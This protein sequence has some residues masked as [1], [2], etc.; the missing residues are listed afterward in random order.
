T[1]HL[2]RY[3]PSSSSSSPHSF[4]PL[5]AAPHTNTSRQYY[6][7][8]PQVTNN[9]TVLYRRGQFQ[10]DMGNNTGAIAIYKKALT[11]NPRDV[12]VLA[13]FGR[14]LYNLKNYTGALRSEDR[15]LSI[16]PTSI[17]ALEWKGF[18]LYHLGDYKQALAT[19][20]RALELN[21]SDYNT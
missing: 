1:I 19:T 2:M 10:A 9:M 5:P 11:I 4:P 21:P 3:N 8:N 6:I 16:D 18:V 20:D 15:A 17:Y 14:V 7:T 13:D 12:Q